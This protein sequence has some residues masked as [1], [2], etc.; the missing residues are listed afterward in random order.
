M[1]VG[2]GVGVVSALGPPS[3]SGSESSRLARCSRTPI[4][5]TRI[6]PR[7]ATTRRRRPTIRQRRTIRQHGAVGTPIT[8]T[9]TLAEYRT[10]ICG[11]S[12]PRRGPQPPSAA[13]TL[14][15]FTPR[16]EVWDGGL[17]PRLGHSDEGQSR[18]GDP[19]Q[20]PCQPRSRHRY[21]GCSR[22][23]KVWTAGI[24]T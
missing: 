5:T 10:P 22:Q 16:Y 15:S 1:Q 18:I 6:I 2:V 13:E 19:L 17:K 20:D 8:D 9:I 23:Q 21:G 24:R 7:T 3:G 14:A 11:K 4:T 12:A